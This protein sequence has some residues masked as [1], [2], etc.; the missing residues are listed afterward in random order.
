MLDYPHAGFILAAYIAA[1]IVVGGLII[2]AVVD[3]RLQRKALDELAARGLG[4]RS[5]SSGHSRR[6]DARSGKKDV[7][8]EVSG[9]VAGP[10]GS[11]PGDGR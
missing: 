8:D 11:K 4:R 1:A 2:R 9:V 10:S 7:T 3:H 6:A 5:P